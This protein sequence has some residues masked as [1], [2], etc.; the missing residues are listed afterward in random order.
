MKMVNRASKLSNWL[1]LS[2]K[3]PGLI[4]EANLDRIITS[5][6]GAQFTIDRFRWGALAHAWRPWLIGGIPQSS[7]I[8]LT[9]HQLEVIEQYFTQASLPEFSSL[10]EAQE[11]YQIGDMLQSNPLKEACAT[12]FRKFLTDETI[13]DIFKLAVEKNYVPLIVACREF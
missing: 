8:D 7:E 5:S 3:L 9:K 13:C 11:F 12:Q 4:E 10:V 1:H 6:D 2:G